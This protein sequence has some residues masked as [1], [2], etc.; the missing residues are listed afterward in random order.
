[1]TNTL[2]YGCKAFREVAYT[3]PITEQQFCA[4]CERVQPLTVEDWSAFLLTSPR[5]V[6]GPPFRPGDVVE[7]RT[8]AVIYD[9]VGT[10]REV[11]MNLKHGGTPIYPTF[12]VELTEKAHDQAP[13]E[14]WYTEI[15]LTKTDAK[16]EVSND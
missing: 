9:G 7:A 14:A 15:C 3:H 8:A 12:R 13:D 1:M 6:L 16:Q 5:S 10:V 11:S 4:D 2:C